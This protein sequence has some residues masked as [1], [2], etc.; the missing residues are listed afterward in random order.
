MDAKGQIVASD[1]DPIGG[2][3]PP[4][5]AGNWITDPAINPRDVIKGRGPK[6]PGRW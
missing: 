6:V 3:G 2:D 1:G 4:T 5:E